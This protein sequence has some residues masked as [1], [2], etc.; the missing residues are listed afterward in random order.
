MDGAAAIHAL[1]RIDPG[2]PIILMSGLPPA[3]DSPEVAGL[4]IQ[5]VIGK[6]FVSE[7]LLILI[8]EVIDRGYRDAEP[9]GDR[10]AGISAK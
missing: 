10:S 7:E 2:I 4:R 6:P 9:V 1:R 5:G 3:M 8:R